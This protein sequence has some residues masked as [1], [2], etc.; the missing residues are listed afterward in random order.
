MGNKEKGLF[1]KKDKTER[2]QKERSCS[3]KM[4]DEK[5]KIVNKKR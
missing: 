2:D 1:L 3:G 4:H 5:K